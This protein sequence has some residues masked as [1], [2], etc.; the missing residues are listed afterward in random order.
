[1]DGTKQLGWVF[2]YNSDGRMIGQTYFDGDVSTPICA[3]SYN[4]NE[5]IVIKTLTSPDVVED[6][7]IRITL[8]NEGKALKK[9]QRTFME[10]K[11]SIIPQ[12]QYI[13][14][15]VNYE[16]DAA[17]L[18]KKTTGG[19]FDSTW[20]NPNDLEIWVDRSTSTANYTT[21]DGNFLNSVE[22][23]IINGSHLMNGTTYH[24]D[25]KRDEETW[26][27]EYSKQYPNKTDFANAA[28][29][30][31]LDI[32]PFVL[33]RNYKKMPDKIIWTLVSKDKNGNLLTSSDG[34]RN[35]TLE[36]DA[37]GYLST[38]SSSYGQFSD[39]FFLAYE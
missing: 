24:F 38:V 1:M 37:K 8:D 23:S 15:T 2:N 27:Y 22:V 4:G 11:G 26:V 25:N 14:D 5:A 16:Y 35:M 19:R 28:L 30:N 29:L 17:G 9:I 34:G 31:E 20:F 12:R 3:I 39:Q 13:Y 33:N 18:L 6:T 32:I 10:F 7:E 21:S 36:Y